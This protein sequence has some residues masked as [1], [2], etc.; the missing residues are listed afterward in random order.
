MDFESSSLRKKKEISRNLKSK[1]WWERWKE[2]ETKLGK[3][4]VETDLKGKNLLHGAAEPCSGDAGDDLLPEESADAQE[5][6]P[7]PLFYIQWHRR[8]EEAPKLNNENLGK[9]TIQMGPYS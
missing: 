3:E 1:L 7:R 6:A 9:V 8:K 4:D 5:D 2:S